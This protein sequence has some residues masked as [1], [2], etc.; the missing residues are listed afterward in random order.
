MKLVVF[1]LLFLFTPCPAETEIIIIYTNNTNGILENCK[2][3]DHAYGAL[4]KR[5]AIIK[6]IRSKHKNVIVLD[7]GDIFDIQQDTLL[8]R[9]VTRAYGLI[10]YDAWTCGD[11]DFIEG[12][13]FFRLKLLELPM[14]LV[15]SNL[16]FS[17]D[18]CSKY[19][20]LKRNNI[21]IGITGSFNPDIFKYIPAGVQKKLIFLNQDSSLRDVLSD[22]HDKS[23]YQ[24][25]LSH[26]GFEKDK[27]LA[28]SFPSLDLIIGGHSQTVLETPE[29]I[30][31]TLI[32]QA[33]ESGY[34][35]GTLQLL[36]KSK[37]LISAQNELI[38]LDKEISDDVGVLK[39][40]NDYHT[41][42]VK[43]K[44]RKKNE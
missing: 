31:T 12:L 7:S 14:K 23:D 8:H 43:Y 42:R 38:L 11:Q 1:L 5:A 24:I 3:P 15:T 2:C 21:R 22:L 16:K 32:V 27:Y 13:D 19:V 30:G 44:K 36:F 4:E 20:I 18:N 33:G 29:K 37:K 39:I 10:R 25:L 17:C 9:A 28:E 6:N 26:S 40:I 34:R 41:K 35:V